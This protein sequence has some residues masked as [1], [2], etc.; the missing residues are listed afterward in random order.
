LVNLAK[1]NPHPIIIGGDFNML[2]YPQEK[3]RG[4]FDT[5]WP[6]LFNAVID[7]LDLKE[8]SM[9]GRQFTWANSLP[10][11]TY[12]KLDRVLMDSDWELKFP[13]VSVRVLPRIEA[14]SDHASILLSTGTPSPQRRRQFKFELG[15]LL[16]EGFSDMIKFIWD[17]PVAGNSP[18]QRWNNKMRSMRRYLGGWS[19]HMTGQLKKEKLSLSSTI[20]DLEAIAE[21]RP[22]TTHEIDLK[23]QLNA[24]LAGLLREEEL[25]WYQ[26]SKSQFLLEGDSNTRYFHS[27]A[28]GRHR[29]KLIHSLVQE[30]GVIEGHEQLKS[31]ITMFYKGLFGTPEESDISMDESRTD[32]IPQVSPQENAILTSPYSEEEIRKAV[33]QMEHNKAPGPDGFP[34][35]FY[36]SFWDIIKVD[37]LELFSELHKGQLDLFRINFGEIILLPKVIDAERIQQYRPICL[38][39]VCFKIFTKVATIRLNSVA[40]QV[41]LPSQTAFMQG[42]Y[43][44][45]GVVTLH[46]T[47]HEMHRKKLNGVI[48]KIDFEKAYDKVKWSFLQQTLRMKGFSDEW[49]ALINN[50]VFEEVLLS[51]SMM[52]LVDI[53]RQKKV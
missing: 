41:V 43:I 36:Q 23:S 24:K 25:K 12:E 9:I 45:D 30:E 48:L 10:E 22:L 46:E 3:S 14:L 37:L 5:H 13:L 33:F 27:V 6:L 7:S 26:R 52:T 34:A 28:N 17:K 50:F 38:L 11:P 49:R 16:R 1:D 32:D 15:W 2:R 20:D 21:V 8:V 35:E 40:D 51:R 4:R 44:L 39:N 53:S 29:K 18:I 31:Y 42:R 47:I 19:K